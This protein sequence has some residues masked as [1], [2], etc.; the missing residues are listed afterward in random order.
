MSRSS[1]DSARAIHLTYRRPYMKKFVGVALA[2][3]IAAATWAQGTFTIR[4]PV[5]GSTVREIV[6]VRI[7]KNSIPEGG[8]LGILVNGKFLEAVMPEVEGNDYIYRL[9]TKKRG[10]ADGPMTLEAVLYVDL[11][12]KPQIINRSS[13]NLKV[14]NYT[15]IKVPAN[16]LSLRYRFNPGAE[17]IYLLSQQVNVSQISQA[18]AQLG[19]RAAEIPVDAERYR[20]LYAVDNAYKTA[21]GREGLIRIQ[22]LPDKGKDYAMVTVTGETE[23][24]KY[25]DYEMHP[26]YMRV[27]DTGREVFGAFPRYFVPEG[28][29]GESFRTD[30][31][32][33]RPLYVLPTKAVKPGDIWQAS[34]QQGVVDLE[35]RDETEKYVVPLPGRGVFEGVEWQ[36]GIPCARL[37]TTVAVG[38]KELKN[39][40]NVNQQPGEAVKIQLEETLWFALDRGIVIR[41]ETLLT[42]ES[43]VTV[44]GGG[45]GGGAGGGSFVGQGQGGGE[46]GERGGGPG[47]PGG[48][49]RGGPGAPAGG[50][51]SMR[52]G[53]T[54]A[55]FGFV[56]DPHLNSDGQI[57]FFRQTSSFG[58][59]P[60]EGSSGGGAGRSGG[61]GSGS[62]GVKQILRI[63]Q[64]SISQ[65]EM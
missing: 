22:V 31:F 54:L 51:K 13:V 28:T 40:E 4:R 1:G 57:V 37:K 32:T 58:A 33:I 2:L 26:V 42:Q 44:Q 29:T 39:L 16:G 64:Q 43:L 55:D 41:Q 10:V 30:L 27:T 20:L 48:R 34:V 12:N 14:D 49:G 3:S 19:S 17:H 5:E 8:Y 59:P 38:Q 45:G 50:D 61:T 47:I 24:K 63:R 6:T 46:E 53:S 15:S 21:N 56:F 62:G 18:A 35:K 60:A 25:Y 7:P 9:N 36:N 23:P 65:L 52:P 11:G